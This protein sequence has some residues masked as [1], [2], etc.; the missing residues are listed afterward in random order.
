MAIFYADS[1][2]INSLSITG[3]LNISGSFSGTASLAV[4]ASYALTSSYLDGTIYNLITVGAS[5]SNNV[6]FYSIKS[7]VDSISTATAD[8]PYLVQVYPGVFIEDTI[9]MKSW[10]T[11]KGDSS[12]ST[13]VSASNPSQSLFVGADQ[14]MIIDMQ[15]QGV[16]APSASAVVY[17]SPTTPQTNAI[18][19][20]ENV[21]FGAN[22]THAKVVGTSGGNCIMQCSNVKYGGYPFTLGFYVT[23]DGSGIG[24]MQLR[25]VTSTNGGV[26]TT[27][28]L[29]FAKADKPGCTFIVNGAL[30]T[31][32]VGTAAG[33]G[34]WVE[35]GGSLRLTAVNFQRWERGIYAPNT[36][37]APSIFGSALNFE[38]NTTDVLVEHT[39]ATGK[40]EGTDTF[41]KTII[42]ADAP[43]YEVNQDPRRLSVARKGGD[44]TS[45]S[46]SVAYITDSSETNR[47]VINVG[48]GEF[49]EKT[50]DLRNKPYVSIVGADIQSTHIMPSGSH[51]QFILG[52]TNEVSFLSLMGNLEPGYAGFVAQDLDG[53]ALIHKVSMYDWDYGIKVVSNVSSSQFFG[54]YVDINGPFSYGTYVSSSNG[55]S[56][57]ASMENYYLF[58]SASAAV[59][60]FV[61]GSGAELDI[62]SS[63]LTGDNT[64]GSIAIM[65]Q[66][67]GQ[68]EAAAVDIQNWEYG[69]KVP[70]SGSA[71]TFRMVGSMIHDSI[72]KDFLIQQSSTQGRFQGLADHSKI[73]N[74]S[75]DFYWNFLDDVDGENDVTRKLSVTF[76]DGTHT[77]ATTLIF[78]GSPMGVQEGGQ[79]SVVTGLT[80]SVSGGFG[81]LEIPNTEIYK[82]LDWPNTQIILPSSSNNYIYFDD[83]GVLL[84]GGTSPSPLTNIIVG[85]AVTDQTSIAFIDQSPYLGAHTAT[86]IS[87]FNKQALGPVYADGSIVTANASVSYSLDVTNG[88]YFF[89]ENQ[90]QPTGGTGITFTRYYRSGSIFNTFDTTI[91]P[92]NVYNSGS[93]LMAM[94][95]SYYTK[96]TLYVVGQGADEQYMLVV[97]QNQYATLIQTEDADLPLPPTYFSDGVVSVASVYVQS[98]STNTI[99]IED[100]RPVIGFK[101]SGINASSVHGNLLGLSADDHTQ[102]LLVDGGREMAADLGLGGFDLIN[103]DRITAN[104]VTSSFTG[105]L[106]GTASYASQAL[107]SSH[108]DRT[109][110]SSYASTSSYILEAISSSYASS[111]TSASYALTS[112][113]AFSASFAL[114]S[115]RT[116]SASFS[117]TSSMATSASFSTTASF[118]LGSVLSSSY[119][120]TASIATSASYSETASF[121]PTYT[122]LISFNDFTSS[123]NT[124]S[125]T[126]SFSGSFSGSYR[127]DGSQLTGVVA[128][129]SPGGADK[130]IQFN[131]NGTTSGSGNFIFDKTA[132][133]VHLTGSLYVTGSNTAPVQYIWLGTAVGA[134]GTIWTNQPAATASFGNATGIA[135]SSSHYIGDFSTSTQ[136]RLFTSLTV[137]AAAANTALIVQ[138]S[139]NN[140][141]W[142]TFSPQLTLGT[143]LGVK[144]T[145][146]A[147]IPATAKDFVYIRLV[148]YGGNGTADPAMSPPILLVR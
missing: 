46:A 39:T 55:S 107:S 124:G 3:S 90:F 81:Y 72:T 41:T 61:V 47:Y 70:N 34:F 27:T 98:G 83:N 50:I 66:N 104:S 137:A 12:I 26:T 13:V 6:D 1:A 18:F 59:G 133:K 141:T 74:N 113:I 38:N 5:G 62:Y 22:Y 24:R 132:N 17:S 9:T 128:S 42:P 121:A 131:D 138:Y 136:C 115:S 14:S 109:I 135:V 145:G 45:I 69:F 71:P 76:E 43:L 116:V 88:N 85:R 108:A 54:E 111:S 139:L 35:D 56:S 142:A 75:P 25:N 29:V 49:I 20:V 119:A 36:G 114:S 86:L 21:R 31:K 40:I 16:T 87:T 63:A 106:L 68:L 102:Y 37:T 130:T 58:P 125:F 2:S 99:Q 91:V 118:L 65:L 11:V 134:N 117:S 101:A 10:V 73:T 122:P 7:A 144:D 112:S 97:G 147:N 92:S 51:D 80:A 44:F 4:S 33:T 143:A 126:G 105:S 64:S 57:F 95:S 78:N 93:A 96:H 67:G 48:P 23:N 77:D 82:R 30:L 129:S 84:S 32:A 52:N 8:N 123:Y 146:W 60:N 94:S 53:F 79:I 103:V 19:Y 100:I 15:I 110:S 148:G 127:G 28:G 120:D 140:V 89:S